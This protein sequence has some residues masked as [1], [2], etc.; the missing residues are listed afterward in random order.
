MLAII[1]IDP[2]AKTPF[3]KFG[4]SDKAQIGDWVVAIG[5][6]YGLDHTVTLGIISAKGRPLI[7]GRDGGM[8]QVYDNMLQT[9]AA[10]NPGNSGGPLSIL[11][12][13]V[14]GIN[15]AVSAAGQGLGFAIPINQVADIL[16]ELKTNGKVSH[17]LDWCSSDGPEKCQG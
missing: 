5:N 12:G 1:K 13:E 16:N 9:D 4:D 6:P 15:S 3:L 2:P 17:P 10:I 11:D 8:S 7:A 14:V